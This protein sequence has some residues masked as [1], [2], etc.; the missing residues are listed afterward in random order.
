MF[1]IVT[2]LLLHWTRGEYGL[3]SFNFI[4]SSGLP[5]S[6]VRC[7]AMSPLVPELDDRLHALG[8]EILHTTPCLSLLVPEQYHADLLLRHCGGEKVLLEQGQ[9]HLFKALRHL[10]GQ[11]VEIRGALE[12]NY[13][14]NIALN[15]CICGNV[16]FGRLDALASELI[17]W[18]HSQG[19]ILKNV[20]QGYAGCATALVSDRALITSDRGIAKA[21]VEEGIDSLLLTPGHIRCDGFDYGFIGGCCGKLAPDVL[22]FSGDVGY[23][24]DADRIGEFCHRHGVSVLSLTSGP[25]IDVGGIIPLMEESTSSDRRGQR[26]GGKVV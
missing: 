9:S 11:P 24:P 13:P 16:L 1:R 25:L 10:G 7:V 2:L 3:S 17:H 20:R 18:A 5:L 21:A 26:G 6:R 15:V 23:H 12:T 22:V 8:V 14:G 19:M 4:R